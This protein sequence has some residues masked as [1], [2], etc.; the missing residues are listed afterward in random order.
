MGDRYELCQKL[1]L[2]GHNSADLQEE[3]K[4]AEKSS[5]VINDRTGAVVATSIAEADGAW[6]AFK[7]LMFRKELPEGHGM[8][9]RPARGIHTHF[10]RFPIDLIF[11]DKSSVVV[12]IRPAMGPWRFDFTSADAVIEMNAGAAI[13]NDIL[14]GDRLVFHSL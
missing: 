3:A 14:S 9:F 2:V 7:G 12:K 1:Y 5:K 4:M 10:M 13:A 6:R 11:L 8:I